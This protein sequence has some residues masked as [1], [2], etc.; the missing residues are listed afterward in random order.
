MTLALHKT[1]TRDVAWRTKG[2]KA[3]QKRPGSTRL[4]C[5]AGDPRVP[6]VAPHT[7]E[8]TGDKRLPQSPLLPAP[9][10]AAVLFRSHWCP[11][12]EAQATALA[13]GAQILSSW[14]A[15]NS[16]VGGYPPPKL[17]LQPLVLHTSPMHAATLRPLQAAEV[18]LPSLQCLQVP[19]PCTPSIPGTST[20]QSLQQRPMHKRHQEPLAA[21]TNLG[22]G[23]NTLGQ[24]SL[25]HKQHP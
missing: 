18:P 17:S 21:R 7:C 11:C 1:P 15:K 9:Q 23:Q 25:G 16:E 8:L 13:P 5:Q 19:A 3:V 6:G 24:S 22:A 10:M 12:P 14:I 2:N 4:V 20:R